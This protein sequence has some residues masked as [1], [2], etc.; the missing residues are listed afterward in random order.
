MLCLLCHAAAALRPPPAAAAA[1]PPARLTR[2]AVLG[3]GVAALLAPPRPASASPDSAAFA[4]AAR[5]L[6]APPAEWLLSSPDVASLDQIGTLLG[7]VALRDVLGA[8]ALPP[9]ALRVVQQ[10]EE[11]K[12]RLGG[13]RA[14]EAPRE[15]AAPPP[16]REERAAP[17]ARPPLPPA[18]ELDVEKFPELKLPNPFARAPPAA[19]PPP[20]SSKP[21][22]L[23]FSAD[24]FTVPPSSPGQPPPPELDVDKLPQIGDLLNPFARRLPP[25]PALPP[26]SP[27]P[28]PPPAPPLSNAAGGTPSADT[29]KGFF[30]SLWG[31]P[32]PPPANSDVMDSIA[33]AAEERRRIYDEQGYFAA[34]RKAQGEAIAGVFGISPP[35]PPPPPRRPPPAAGAAAA[36]PARPAACAASEPGC[37]QTDRKASSATPSGFMAPWAFPAARGVEQAQADLIKALRAEGGR[38]VRAQPAG[39]GAVRVRASFSAGVFGAVLLSRDLT[40]E[41]EFVLSP[42]PSKGARSQFGTA[43]FRAAASG[44]GFP[45]STSERGVE[46]NRERLL[47][48]R[49]RLFEKNGWVCG[50]EEDLN[51]LEAFLCSLTC[52]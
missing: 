27:P 14:D 45:F 42:P 8:D 25:P 39:G 38:D 43:S 6:G 51:P 16:S 47:K 30:E 18:E 40:D 52:S 29:P 41:V 37:L 31:P 10:A 5:H 46:R 28:P 48:V 1:L 2:R 4:A 17:P 23:G 12:L 35:P 19:P 11:R 22:Y 26:P 15:E 32:P 3:T 44:T 36:A 7:S 33:A 13:T 24:S 20:P 9:G 50:C 49:K 21:S 34:V